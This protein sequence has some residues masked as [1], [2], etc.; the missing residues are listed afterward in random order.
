MTANPIRCNLPSPFAWLFSLLLIVLYPGLLLAQPGSERPPGWFHEKYGWKA[1]AY[2]SDA[3]QIELCRAILAND[4][5]GIERA[6]A[7]GADVNAR[8]KGGMTPL[9]WAYAENNPERLKKLLE[10]GADPNATWESDFNT[11]GT[12]VRPG[13]AVTLMVCDCVFDHYFD[14]VFDHG[15]NPNLVTEA[16]GQTPI[17]TLIVGRS[18]DKLKKL[19][20][21]IELGADVD[22]SGPGKYYTPVTY[23][24]ASGEYA[25]ALE[26]AK[27]GADYLACSPDHPARI[28]HGLA[29]AVP[30][31]DNV[32]SDHPKRTAFRELV[33]WLAEKGESL[34]EAQQDRTRWRKWREQGMGTFN[35]NAKRE[36]QAYLKRLEQARSQ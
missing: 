12:I 35:A 23:A 30:W 9:L 8:G 21:L 6:V 24:V 3:A 28:I 13:D 16:R 4:L 29:A 31:A 17:R 33:E 34:A 26:L 15:G 18:R 2:Y 5:V 7:N 32:E 10:L 19:K 27:S 36:A 14:H 20:R 1:E 25:L 11:K 22:N